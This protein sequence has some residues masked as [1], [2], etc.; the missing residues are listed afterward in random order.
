MVVGAFQPLFG[1]LARLPY[2]VGCCIVVDCEV[3]SIVHLVAPHYTDLTVERYQRR[4][5]VR[6]ER[7]A[8]HGQ[9]KAAPPYKIVVERAVHIDLAALCIRDPELARAVPC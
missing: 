8:D 6:R 2:S 1:S 5:I 7:G 9:H 3:E 4:Y